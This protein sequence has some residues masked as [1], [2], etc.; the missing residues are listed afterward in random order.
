MQN[1]KTGK[2]NSKQNKFN[3]MKNIVKCSSTLSKYTIYNKN[4]HKNYQK[5]NKLFI[6]Y[7]FFFLLGEMLIGMVFIEKK[8]VRF[9]NLNRNRFPLSDSYD[10]FQG[11]F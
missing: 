2:R 3:Y 5:K 11:P 7:V 6:F 9:K 8:V 4:N 1:W 10:I